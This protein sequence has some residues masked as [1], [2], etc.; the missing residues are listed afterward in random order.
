MHFTSRQTLLDWVRR[1]RLD[2]AQL[3]AALDLCELPPGLAR[4]QW[5]FD[6]LLLWLG[7]LCLGA[8]L[9]FF[10][11][12]NWQELGRLSRLALL[13]LPLLAMLLLL[14]R[15]PLAD[16]QRQALLLAIA[17]NIGALLALVGQTYQTGADPWQ[18]FATW[19]LMLLPL[20]ALGQ[21]PLLWTMSWLLGQLAL[22]LY[23]R[24]GLF[25]LFFAFD[26][27]AL[28]WSLTLFNAA[29]W[30]ILL[31]VPAHYRLMPSWLAGLA[32]GLGV[33]LLTLLALF[34]AASPWV[35]PAWLGWLAA[36][37]L[38]WQH[39]FIAG[40]AMGCL[41][42]IVVLLTALGKWMEPDVDGFLLL[43]LIAIG[44]SVAASRWLQQQ[45]RSHE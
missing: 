34:D 10:V 33:T 3:P 19:A 5:L 21:S 40:L 38:R 4:W 18:L 37:Y 28:G 7:S 44:L 16:S 23:W 17:L 39:R 8:G 25:N 45:R 32:A 24:L 35:W 14:W 41:S 12:F 6:R 27:E 43:C 2:R 30:G 42:L 31:L 20:A 9:V 11:A 36:A 26:E 13:E 22:V 15:K 1:G 29:L